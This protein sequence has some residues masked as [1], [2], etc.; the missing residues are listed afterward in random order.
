[1]PGAIQGFH[2]RSIEKSEE[3][4]ADGNEQCEQKGEGSQT[5]G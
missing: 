5:R 4:T 2:M 1:M 3:Q